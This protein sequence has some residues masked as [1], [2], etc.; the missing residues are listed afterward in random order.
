MGQDMVLFRTSFFL[1]LY[2]SAKFPI[3]PNI[4]LFPARTCPTNGTIS[5]DRT[6]NVI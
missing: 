3:H 2:T 4:T 6:G 1:G 5:T